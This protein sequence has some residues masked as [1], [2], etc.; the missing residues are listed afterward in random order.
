MNVIT[1]FFVLFLM[2]GGLSLGG[3]SL[4][5]Q[6][7]S[8]SEDLAMANGEMYM[9]A[10]NISAV[11][12]LQE[13]GNEGGGL[14]AGKKIRIINLGAIVNRE[15]Y[16]YAPTISADGKTLYFVSDRPGG[17][18]SEDED[19]THDFWYV[20]K[21]DRLDTTFTEP[22]NLDKTMPNGPIASVNTRLN[23][24]AASIAA[25]RQ[26]LYFTACDRADG[27]GSCDIYLTTIE[28]DNW[29]RPVNLGRNVNSKN[30]DTQPAITADQSRL[31]FVSTREGPNSD[32]EDVGENFDIW[33]CDYDFDLEEWGP[34]K[35]L[36]EIN[37]KGQDASPF[38]GADGV[39]M[40]FAS[41]GHE[42]NYGFKDFYVTR[43]NTSDD[44]WSTPENLGEPINTDQD[45]QFITLPASG[46]IIYWSSTRQDLDGYQG[47]LDIFMAFVPSFFKAVNVVGTVVDECSGDFIP[48]LIEIKNPI[49]GKTWTDSV[50][51]TKPKFEKIITNDDY[52]APED[53][54][55]YVNLEITAINDTYGRTTQIQRVDKPEVTENEDEAGAVALEYNLELRLGQ[56]PVLTPDVTQGEFVKKF[57][58]SVPELKGFDGLVMKK[59]QSWDLYPLLNY[60]FFDIGKSDI[61]DRY[62]LLDKDETNYF[63]DTTIPGGTLDK[64]YHVLNIYGF[65]LN[66]YPEVKI[67]VIGCNDN[68]TPDEKGKKKTLSKTR[69]ENVYNYLRDVWGISEDRMKI[70]WRDFP[71]K[72]AAPT[73]E[74][75]HQE[76][77]RVE[78]L[79]K[80]WRV[81][82]PVFEKDPKIFPQPEEME[83][84][85]SNGIQDE[86]IDSK[87]VVVTRGGT[88]WKE[89]SGISTDSKSFKWNWN[90]ES[91]EYPVQPS[92]KTMGDSFEATLYVTTK[93]G[94]VCKSDP[95]TIPVYFASVEDRVIPMDQD[96]TI[97]N[98]S[99]IL[100]PFNSYAA[101][102]LNDKIMND[103]V[104]GRVKPSSKIE[105]IGHTDNTGLDKG[106]LRLSKNRAKT[107]F[108]GIKKKSRG[109]YEQLH[110]HGVG[111]EEPLYDNDLPEG[112]M[113]NRTVQVLIKTPVSAYSK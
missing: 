31:Y 47:S 92:G 58:A 73:D 57:G 80:D 27:L 62:I 107:V 74:I 51:L 45:E 86:I 26:S 85:M 33:Y 67:E 95:V 22:L 32:G 75:H 101:G 76:N 112:R 17:V 34:A 72:K 13:E 91:S 113:Y 1:R 19:P 35:N 20:K 53:S 54:N 110:Q 94:A 97:E 69:A 2:I 25:D 18:L 14:M 105:V 99:L 44:S 108:T 77:R 87:K 43:L 16:D 100:F 56:Q 64:Y 23:E 96:S 81:M 3:T 30:Y 90:N 89:F 7:I 65:R 78:I 68:K 6:Q 88:P 61:P 103:Y 11:S 37:T 5:S 82:K 40:F 70:S 21:E 83:F 24:G 9:M 93:S 84:I 38:I 15:G 42:P 4:F 29:G 52:G 46:D 55:M 8:N 50:T 36:E 104:Y 59:V 71:K 10:A 102:P 12:P 79:C 48:A 111:E 41:D 66:Q 98:Y 49:T 63:A 39:T 28:G 60:I 109:K 106:N